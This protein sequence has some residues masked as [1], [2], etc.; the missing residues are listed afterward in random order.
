MPTINIRVDKNLKLKSQKI[1]D[2][3]G[4]GMTSAITIYLKAVIRNNGIPF[5]LEIPNEK[6]IKAFK[7]I[8]HKK[9]SFKKYSTSKD[10]RKDL[11]V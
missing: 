4:I 10:L 3:L 7:E 9:K 11:G 1:F 8:E 2:E 5:N 6:T